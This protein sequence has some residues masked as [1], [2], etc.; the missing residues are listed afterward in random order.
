MR[1]NWFGAGTAVGVLVVAACGSGETP[2]AVTRPVGQPI[3]RGPRNAVVGEFEQWDRSGVRVRYR[4]GTRLAVVFEIRNR[5]G[6]PVTIRALGRL[7]PRGHLIRL[8][9]TVFTRVEA[10]G[11]S[12]PPR[13]RECG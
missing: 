1:R 2:T 4:K 5:A 10:P 9:G 3:A 12:C 6:T 13:V 8:V 7:R 11:A